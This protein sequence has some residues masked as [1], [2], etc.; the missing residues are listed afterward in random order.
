MIAA[1]LLPGPRLVL[2]D[3]PTTALDVTSQSEVMAVLSDLQTER[4]V[5]MVFIT[6]DLDLAAAVTDRIA[7]MYAGVVVETGPD[8]QH[9]PGV[10]CTPTR[11][12]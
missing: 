1:V 5:G 3:E 4:G 6:H 8:G 10:R 11:W 12:R 9:A 2:A 7:V